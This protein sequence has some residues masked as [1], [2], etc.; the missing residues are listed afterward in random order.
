LTPQGYDSFL[1]P[2]RWCSPDSPG[3]SPRRGCTVGAGLDP[4]AQSRRQRPPEVP[5]GHL[6]P[7]C[8]W[9]FDPST[10][11]RWRDHPWAAAWAK[12]PGPAI[13]IE[14]SFCWRQG[15]TA[16]SSSFDAILLAS[17]DNRF[18]PLLM[19]SAAAHPADLAPC[20][21]PRRDCL[22]PFPRLFSTQN[23]ATSCRRWSRS[24]VPIRRD[25]LCA[26]PDCR[27]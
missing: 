19:F 26:V 8:G 14:P 22:C 17:S 4:P 11:D 27:S 18:Q 16:A 21:R 3:D 15:R 5:M 2:R 24:Y 23:I 9:T 25:D 1:V 13:I 6:R 20:V 7:R 10:P 12:L